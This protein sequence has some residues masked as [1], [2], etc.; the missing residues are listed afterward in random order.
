MQAQ[1]ARAIAAGAVIGTSSAVIC[2]FSRDTFD[3]EHEART[4]AASFMTDA[5]TKRIVRVRQQQALKL[6]SLLRE[7]APR[8]EQCR[9]A[10]SVVCG[11]RDRAACVA[12]RAAAADE[13]QLLLAGLRAEAALVSYSQASAE[14]RD[15]Y[16]RKYGCVAWTEA[17]LDA[18]ASRGPLVEIGA[19]MGQWAQALRERGV[20]VMAYDD[21]SDVPFPAKTRGGSSPG[22][23][24]GVGTD[25][26]VGSRDGHSASVEFSAT[27][28]RLREQKRMMKKNG[29]LD[30]IDGVEAASMHPDRTLLLVAPPPGP[31]PKAWL[32]AYRGSRLAYAGEGRGGAHADEGFFSALEAGWRLVATGELQPFPGGSEKLWLLER[33]TPATSNANAVQ[34]A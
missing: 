1:I 8:I 21:G 20:D 6:D 7:A 22:A 13:Y 29:V 19:G 2:R 18:V 16:V 17:A 11:L 15:T 10:A 26:G 4:A 30:S 28:Q 31:K 14:E 25:A 23:A 9:A 5:A 33:K 34:Q 32:D 3:A 12:A 24:S 27:K